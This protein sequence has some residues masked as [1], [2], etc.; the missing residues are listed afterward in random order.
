ALRFRGIASTS[1]SQWNEFEGEEEKA[2]KDEI[3]NALGDE[4][5]FNIDRF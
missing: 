3:D 5:D 2:E 4:G 1:D